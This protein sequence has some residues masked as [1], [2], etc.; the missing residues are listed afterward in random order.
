MEGG[1]EKEEIEKLGP[2]YM[3]VLMKIEGSDPFKIMEDIEGIERVRN[4][5]NPNAS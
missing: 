2:F 1:N 4:L 3:M 5:L